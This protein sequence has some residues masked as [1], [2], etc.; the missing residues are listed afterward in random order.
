MVGI[1]AFQSAGPYERP[2][3][4]RDRVVDDWPTDTFFTARKNFN[5][6]AS[7]RDVE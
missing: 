7:H 4:S 3:A 5:M 6:A 2:P 1:I